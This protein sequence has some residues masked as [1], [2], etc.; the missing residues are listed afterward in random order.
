MRVLETVLKVLDPSIK[1]VRPVEGVRNSFVIQFDH[2][3]VIIQDGKAAD[4]ERL[5]AGTYDGI[6]VAEILSRIIERKNGFYYCDEKFSCIQS[7]VERAILSVMIDKLPD[8]EQLFFTTLNS[9][10][11]DMP[12]PKHTF[13]FLKKN[14]QFPDQPI[15]VINADDYLKRNTDSLRSAVENDLFG[16]TPDVDALFDLEEYAGR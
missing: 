4:F 1:H 9:D 3:Q 6:A 13:M 15:T 10:V 8:Y 5:S 11:L 14:V 7:D 16:V 2:Q 12:Y